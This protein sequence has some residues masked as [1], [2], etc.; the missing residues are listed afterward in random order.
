MARVS[1]LSFRFLWL[2]SKAASGAVFCKNA[3]LKTFALFTGKQVCGILFVEALRPATLLKRDSN[4]S[5]FLWVLW[6]FLQ[7]LFWRISAN[8]CFGKLLKIP[9]PVAVYSGQEKWE[10]SKFRNI[11]WKMPVENHHFVKFVDYRLVTSPTFDSITDFLKRNFRKSRI[12]GTTV[13]SIIH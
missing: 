1:R 11:P 10:L 4:A 5:I 2:C 9:M 6:N 13:D 7:Y 12:T 8:S 3:V